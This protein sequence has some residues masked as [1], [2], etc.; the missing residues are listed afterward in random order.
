MY[1]IEPQMPDRAKSAGW[2]YQRDFAAAHAQLVTA[3]AR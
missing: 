3:P 1:A 2:P